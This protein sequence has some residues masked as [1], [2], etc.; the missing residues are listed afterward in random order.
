MRPCQRHGGQARRVRR[1][2][3]PAPRG[4]RQGQGEVGYVQGMEERHTHGPRPRGSRR[5]PQGTAE[6]RAMPRRLRAHLQVTG[7]NFGS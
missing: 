6:T 5:T 7:C 2:D 1:S 4:P 3:G